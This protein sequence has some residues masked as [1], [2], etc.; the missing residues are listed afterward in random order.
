MPNLN[1]GIIRS[2][3]IR[4]PS[5]DEQQS[6]ASLLSFLDDKIELNRRMARTL[7]EMARALFR[8][9]FADFDPVRAKMEGRDPALP[10]DAADLF[11]DRFGDDG[12]PE[13]WSW[14]S[15]EAIVKNIVDR[16]HPGPDTV[17]RPYVPVDCIT[18]RSTILRD[19]RPGVEAASSLVSFQE[20]D[21]LFGAMRPYFYKVALAPW[22]GTTRTTVFVLR[23]RLRSDRHFVLSMLDQQSTIDFATAHSTG[24]TIPYAVWEGSMS[25]MPIAVPPE[26]LRKIYGE[27]VSGLYVRARCAEDQSRTLA[28]L[29]DALLPRLISGE[30]RIPDAEALVEEAA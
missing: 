28:A 21:V 5:F 15:L 14:A 4:L 8:S 18:A 1:E 9:W 24:S 3:P 7:E 13:G 25:D 16:C 10:A 11:P 26:C 30:L 20:G 23:P 27:I 17:G 12:L 2:F 29:R 19:G 6:I 22:P